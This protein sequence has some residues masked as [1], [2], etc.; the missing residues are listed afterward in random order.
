MEN[1]NEIRTK[2][3]N[4]EINKITEKIRTF[5]E[6]KNKNNNNNDNNNNARKKEIDI[7]KIKVDEQFDDFVVDVNGNILYDEGAIND[8]NID[9]TQYIEDNFICDEEE[10]ENNNINDT[11]NNNNRKKKKWNTYKKGC[12]YTETTKYRLIYNKVKDIYESNDA[13]NFKRPSVEKL[14]KD[15]LRT[16]ETK[17]RI[18]FSP[19][20]Y[21][22]SH[23]K[24]ENRL[25]VRMYGVDKFGRTICVR[26]HGFNP[27]FYMSV[28]EGW[29]DLNIVNFLNRFDD[30]MVDYILENRSDYEQKYERQNEEDKSKESTA[31]K[32]GRG[33]KGK[34]LQKGQT[35][36]IQQKQ[37]EGKKEG[38]AE[39]EEYF[40]D[41]AKPNGKNATNRILESLVLGNTIED[42][43]SERVEKM[44]DLNANLVEKKT[45]FMNYL[46]VG[47]KEGDF[48]YEKRSECSIFP[49][50]E[51]PSIVYKYKLKGFSTDKIKMIK[52]PMLYPKMVPLV[53]NALYTLKDGI[54]CQ[55]LS[56]DAK[57]R[58]PSHFMVWSADIL[59]PM[60][61]IVDT[62]IN[63]MWWYEIEE[64][65]YFIVTNEV[66]KKTT[67]QYEIGVNYKDITKCKDEKINEVHPTMIQMSYDIECM[68]TTEKFVEP[69]T[70]PVIQIGIIFDRYSK[71]LEREGSEEEKKKFEGI[72]EK[73]KMLK[74]GICLGR[75]SEK[76][77]RQPDAKVIWVENEKELFMVFECIKNIFD[78]DMVTGYNNEWFDNWYLLVRALNI[79]GMRHFC[80]WGRLKLENGGQSYIRNTST[81]SRAFGTRKL[82]ETIAVGVFIFDLMQY[83]SK[84]NNSKYVGLGA[85]AMSVLGKTKDEMDYKKIPEYQHMEDLL[86]EYE[87]RED[88]MQYCLKDA[89]LCPEIISV[90][91]I[92]EEVF[93]AVRLIKQPPQMI[94]RKGATSGTGHMIE[95]AMKPRDFVTFTPPNWWPDEPFK[96][97]FGANVFQPQ[98]AVKNLPNQV[99]I[100][101]DFAGLYPAIINAENLCPSTKVTWRFIQEK[102]PYWKRDEDYVQIGQRVISKD[103][104]Q[105]YMIYNNEK[106]SFFVTEKHREGILPMFLTYLRNERSAVKR[107]MGEIKTKINASESEITKS[108]KNDP[109]YDDKISKL[110]LRIKYLK[111]IYSNL[112]AKQ[113]AIKLRMNSTYGYAGARFLKGKSDPDVAGAVTSTGKNMI[114]LS[115][116]RAENI[117][118]PN[119]SFPFSSE[120]KS[121]ARVLYGDSVT[122]NSPLL[123]RVNG[124]T[125]IM[126]IE[127]FF[128]DLNEEPMKGD[129]GKEHKPMVDGVEVWSEM[130]W[131]KIQNVMRHLSGKR[132]YRVLTNTGYVEVTEDHSLLR[133]DGEMVTPLQL[134]KGDKLMSNYPT[135][136]V[137]EN[138][139]GFI[140][141]NEGVAFGLGL[142]V[143]NG[144]CGSYNN[145]TNFDVEYSWTINNKDM[146]LLNKTKE[147][148]EPELLKRYGCTMKILDTLKSSG[149]YK[150][151][152]CKEIKDIDL[153][154]REFCYGPNKEKIIPECIMNAPMNIK[155]SFFEGL[156][157]GD[158]DKTASN[159]V[160]KR[161]DAKSQLSAASYYAFFKSMGY[162]VSVNTRT[163]E[164]NIYGLTLTKNKQRKVHNKIKKIE[165]LNY[166]GYVYDLTTENHHFQAGVG[167]IIVHNTDSIFV[168]LDF[169]E[170]VLDVE[171]KAACIGYIT[172]VYL[173]KLFKKPND[174]ALEKISD[175]VIFFR[176]KKYAYNKKELKIPNLQ[177]LF[178]DSIGKFIEELEKIGE[179]AMDKK[180]ADFFE[181][182][183]AIRVV[184]NQMNSSRIRYV[185]RS[186]CPLIE[187]KN[188]DYIDT[189]NMPCIP[190][191]VH[192]Q[193]MEIENNKEKYFKSSLDCWLQYYGENEKVIVEKNNLYPFRTVIPKSE[194]DLT[195]HNM[196]HLDEFIMSYAFP[197]I[198]FNVKKEYKGIESARKDNIEF[199][200]KFQS[201]TL[202][203]L[204]ENK[205]GAI[206][207]IEQSIKKAMMDLNTGKI[208]IKEL[209]YSKKISKPLDAYDV[210][211]IHIAFALHENKRNPSNPYKEGDKVS[212]VIVE[213]SKNHKT[214]ECG[215]SPMDVIEGKYKINFGKIRESFIKTLVRTCH[216]IYAGHL[217][218]IFISPYC[219]DKT[220][221]ILRAKKR[222]ND[223]EILSIIHTKLF[224]GE[225][226]NH[227]KQTT[228]EDREYIVRNDNK[229]QKNVLMEYI[230]VIKKCDVC[231]ETI[232]DK[233]IKGRICMECLLNKKFESKLVVD[234]YKNQVD[235]TTHNLSSLVKKCHEC[236]NQTDN[237][238]M[239]IDCVNTSCGT[240]WD[241]KEMEKQVK[242]QSQKYYTI[243]A[244]IE[245]IVLDGRLSDENLD[246]PELQTIISHETE[247]HSLFE[248]DKKGIESMKLSKPLCVNSNPLPNTIG[249]N[250]KANDGNV[251][252]TFCAKQPKI[253]KFTKKI[254]L[255]TIP[256]KLTPSGFPSK[257]TKKFTNA[258][259]SNRSKIVSKKI[260]SKFDQNK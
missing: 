235:E 76:L 144:S 151:V 92:R 180:R 62:E 19:I 193:Y 58:L 186:N 239:Q 18:L 94:M 67:C 256:L 167:D 112:D 28:P 66:Q 231:K 240:L 209:I 72:E 17:E 8:N 122:G 23:D 120:L 16:N 75:C 82:R 223:K 35:T 217:E 234:K 22:Y 164:P 210:P 125:K 85:L 114:M 54:G 154:W 15:Y 247:P 169:Y 65:K 14:I 60:R 127:Q 32:G 89:V 132:I 90:K 211:P 12:E 30:E 258:K 203:T 233:T 63:P 254:S 165:I 10:I 232:N 156:Y 131:T 102:V 27:Y 44:W 197:L 196:F 182:H 207:K 227:F 139:K 213:K 166:E 103:G 168:L 46:D 161:I 138:Y 202:N 236:K 184:N 49:K 93:A 31:K 25:Y 237:C 187:R 118:I 178:A 40:D 206:D 220:K 159:G 51:R 11:D 34:G 152:V 52:L 124:S 126:T 107:E 177:G 244:D 36:L 255:Q 68:A 183:C 145:E 200:T 174:L 133:D 163:D 250:I 188:L 155:N 64:K 191:I 257:S 204:L 101:D 7:D 6:N 70:D 61:F 84:Q 170:D 226:M 83:Q 50:D 175:V 248:N 215:R 190:D 246:E 230:Y 136:T 39:K 88:L 259:K 26:A 80:K 97:F 2:R 147:L 79:F 137:D 253:L 179:E 3:K 229:R 55:Y 113:L 78:P 59:Y 98:A 69:E 134:K 117:Y 95:I 106:D 77:K 104:K 189:N 100:I 249:I 228:F 243:L 56:R 99:E 110:K 160:T 4:E 224:V 216:P 171:K 212:Y 157:A 128:N 119:G 162:E 241:R 29:S 219:D 198:E 115:K 141:N 142:F 87:E 116:F 135:T 86:T 105:C 57:V 153:A 129:D 1:K 47:V 149:V 5:G 41:Q 158:G 121:P 181:K 81:T 185:T 9:T 53:K 214:S 195:V 146:N 20:D 192:D 96:E 74:I 111:I 148:L 201:Y 73:N 140:E 205:P 238:T 245:D 221:K 45:Y 260:G 43:V 173:S 222:E 150:L 176:K 33:K 71:I 37:P 42:L 252:K 108:D 143:A 91:S 199:I 242:I 21:D 48:V 218:N 251:V 109:F 194:K 225:H 13:L 38:K 123:L 130:G 172:S 24:E 208:K